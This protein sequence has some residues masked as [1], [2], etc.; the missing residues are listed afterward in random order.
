MDNMTIQKVPQTAPI[1]DMRNRQTEL[2]RM[3]EEGPVILM[4][5]S[6]PS[7]ILISPAQWNVI[8]ERWEE[9]QQ[10]SRD[11]EDASQAAQNDKTIDNGTTV[12]ALAQI[13]A[14]AQPLGPSDLSLNFDHYTEQVL[15]DAAAQ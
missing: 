15:D 12:D 13:A 8:A 6:K 5:R 1:S 9:V 7:A 2:L 11:R 14:M 10:K 3:A 4:S